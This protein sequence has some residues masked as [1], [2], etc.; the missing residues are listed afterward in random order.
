MPGGRLNVYLSDAAIKLVLLDEIN[1]TLKLKEVVFV[2]GA[3]QW[4]CSRF[5]LCLPML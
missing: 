3:G 5:S 2:E 4:G 1:M